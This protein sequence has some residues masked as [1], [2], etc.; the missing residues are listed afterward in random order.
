MLC[1]F[2]VC[3]C[4]AQAWMWVR[5]CTQVWW[6]ETADSESSF[7]WVISWERVRYT[8]AHYW[9]AGICYHNFRHHWTAKD[10]SRSTSVYCS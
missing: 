3:R 2:K 8:S 1:C 4:F 7:W 9:S 5:C 6:V 10:C